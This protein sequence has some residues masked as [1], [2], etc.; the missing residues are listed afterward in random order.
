MGGAN[1]VAP[2]SPRNSDAPDQFN[3]S[4]AFER[5]ARIQGEEIPH[6][7]GSPEN[8]LVRERL[9]SEIKS[10]GFIPETTT[11]PAC[12]ANG[13]TSFI[14]CTTVKNVSFRMGPAPIPGKRETILA[15]SHYDSVPAGP[16][17]A[18]AKLGVGVLL[19]TAHHL[20][21]QDLKRPILFLITDGEEGG[22][23]G[24]RAFAEQD[25]RADEIDIVVNFEARGVEGPAFMFET[26]QPNGAVIPQFMKSAERPVANSLMAAIYERLPNSTDVAV[27]L[28]SGWKALNF[29]IIGRE[30]YYHTPYDNLENLSLTSLQHMGDLSLSTLQ[31]LATTPPS[32]EKSRL[33]Y[34]DIFGRG[35]IAMPEN[36]AIPIMG[37]AV[38]LALVGFFYLPASENR[39]PSIFAGIRILITPLIIII[40]AGLFGFILQWIVNSI[41]PEADYWRAH[42]WATHGW[43]TLAGILPA[44]IIPQFIA[45]NADRL[46]LFAAA[47]LWFSL[48]GLTAAILLPGASIL[49]VL[50]AILFSIGI[51]AGLAFSPA[52][53]VLEILAAVLSLVLLVPII[54][55]LGEGLGYGIAFV[56][57]ILTATALLPWLAALM[58][59]PVK[60]IRSLGISPSALVALGIG[61]FVILASILPAYSI[62]APR[63]LNVVTYIDQN[64]G[65]A[66][67]TF[68]SSNT[69]PPKEMRAIGTIKKP[70]KLISAFNNDPWH[71]E[72]AL[73]DT[74][75]TIKLEKISD[76]ELPDGS[77]KITL[78]VQA[79]EADRFTLYVP[80]VLSPKTL[81]F[82][83]LT[84][85]IGP[86]LSTKN[87][88]FRCA[89][90]SCSDKEIELTIDTPETAP[91]LIY[92]EYFGARGDAIPFVEARPPHTTARQSGDRTMVI[93]NQTL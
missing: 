26:S 40:A 71:Q 37:G 89:G 77:H 79:G 54:A 90:R 78:R 67:L 7:V 66:W 31:H 13:S 75:P 18:D 10:L 39:A 92:S 36:F 46:H 23:F 29:A 27:Y 17:A 55:T 5:I 62:K 61:V 74:A 33:I 50:P 38:I 81:S 64:A 20:A 58:T 30:A 83:G 65:K 16:G 56:L 63:H 68:G 25:S 57:S 8:H 51:L 76:L 85:E 28:R 88:I 24:A 14:A 42:S 35:M 19:E 45:K 49:F 3:T 73:P 70:Q 80:T 15:T 84:T 44:L 48:I 1:L 60:N 9:L 43:A 4:R 47:W 53:I 41:R 6:P 12:L 21:E 87:M 82:D 34:T 32:Q 59:T 91:F 2:S 11:M 52:S 86:S 69:P 93:Y 72:I 22:L